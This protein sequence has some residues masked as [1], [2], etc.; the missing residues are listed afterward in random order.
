V[1]FDAEMLDLDQLEEISVQMGAGEAFDAECAGSELGDDV[2]ADAYA[3][4]TAPGAASGE[5]FIDL[6]MLYD[7]TETDESDE[8]SR[9]L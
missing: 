6:E 4:T 1:E 7:E 9:F 5:I 8:V 2:F 3:H